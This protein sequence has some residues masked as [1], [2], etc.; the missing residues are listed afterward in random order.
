[1]EAIFKEHL[2]GYFQGRVI[3]AQSFFQQSHKAFM[4]AV[5]RLI[6]NLEKEL[7][8]PFSERVDT[9]DDELVDPRVVRLSMIHEQLDQLRYFQDEENFT[10]YGVKLITSISSMWENSDYEAKRIIQFLVFPN[11]VLF[12]NVTRTFVNNLGVIF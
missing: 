1:L 11:G 10:D 5:P 7:R 3:E 6:K 2:I 8:Q 4:P 12:D 9:L